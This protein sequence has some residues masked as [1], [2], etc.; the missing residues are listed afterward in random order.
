M[1][2]SKSTAEEIW[3][4][5]QQYHGGQEWA[6]LSNYVCDFSVTTN[7]FG[8]PQASFARF[9][10]AFWFGFY[11]HTHTHSQKAIDI[12]CKVMKEECIH[13]PA[14]DFEPALTKLANYLTPP[15]HASIK[16]RFTLGSGLSELI[17]IVTRMAPPGAWRPGTRCCR[18]R[19]RS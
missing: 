10:V 1:R 15:G 7:C 19:S 11:S 18:L 12:A 5:Q 9:V 6:L 3:T 17:D 16:P 8:V 14:A 13:Y 4:E 2:R